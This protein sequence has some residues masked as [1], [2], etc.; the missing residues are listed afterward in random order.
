[1][2]NIPKEKPIIFAPNHQNAMMDPLALIF[3]NPL[4]TTFLARSDIFKN[5]FT[6]YLLHRLKILPVYRIRD[7][8][9]SLKKNDAIFEQSIQILKENK[10]LA[11]FP[12]GTHNNKHQLL[13][14]KKAI[15]RIAFKALKDANYEMDIQVIPV[16]IY[17]KNYWKFRTRL[18]INY[19]KAISL[20]DYADIL[21]E[22]ENKATKIFMNDLKTGLN[23]QM[24][25][26]ESKENYQ[27]YESIISVHTNSETQFASE[28]QQ[29]KA[30]YAQSKAFFMHHPGQLEQIKNT[31]GEYKKLKAKY[32]L[33]DEHV[34]EINKFKIISKSL[35]YVVTFP[36]FLYGLIHHGIF[37]AGIKTV[38]NKIVKD[39]Q[40]YSTFQFAASLVVFPILHLTLAIICFLISNNNLAISIAYFLSLP[41]S[42]VFSFDYYDSFKQTTKTI[43]FNRLSKKQPK[44][45]SR[46]LRLK[47]E[48]KDFGL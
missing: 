30:L 7:G 3:T 16:G 45:Y 48:I 47:Q 4:Q 31:I 41:L 19:G 27:V 6:K 10:P 36:I 37:F 46:L 25:N 5:K 15:P 24:L 33:D 11:L 13:P 32:Q 14:L 28:L 29:S 34:K 1:M 20:K 23:K 17:H 42:G 35:F 43:K 9:S 2:E 21:K 18:E 22:D 39:R 44:E 38:V 26:I 40:F 12:E 8:V